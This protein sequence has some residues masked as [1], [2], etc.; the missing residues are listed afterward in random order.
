MKAIKLT[1][2]VKDDNYELFK[3]KTVGDTFKFNPPKIF[4]RNNEKILGYDK[5]YDL[6][7]EDG[8]VI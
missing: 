1:Q 5:R 7:E 3:N 4:I 2:R 8:F 6:H